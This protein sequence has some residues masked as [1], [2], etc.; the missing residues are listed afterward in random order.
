MSNFKNPFLEENFSSGGIDGQV[1]TV[2]GSKF[3]L[4]PWKNKK[5]EPV[6]QRDNPDQQVVKNVWAITWLTEK[7][8]EW[9]EK[10]SIGGLIPTNDGEGFLKPQDRSPGTLNARSEAAKL[11]TFITEGGFDPSKLYDP[12][13]GLAKASGLV[14]GQFELK[15]VDMLDKDKKVKTREYEGKTYTEQK[16]YLARFIGFK[17]GVGGNGAVAE[18]DET[19]ETARAIITELLGAAEGGKLTRADMIRQINAKKVDGKILRLA[20]KDSFHADAPW[21]REANGSLSI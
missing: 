10:Y 18:D 9:T 3:E 11:S 6:M 8:Q 14:G 1:V 17:E 21:T 19:V 2:I 4:D 7:D 13:T 5:G 15:G 20:L 16:K 12:E